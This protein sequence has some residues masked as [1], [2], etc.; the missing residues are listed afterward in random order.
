MPHSR[1]FLVCKLSQGTYCA[2][3]VCYVDGNKRPILPAFLEHNHSV[4]QGK[5][6]MV[7]SN[8]HILTGMVFGAALPHD[9]IAGD[10]FLTAENLNTESLAF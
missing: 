4:A 5:E 3:R 1:A 9:N 7:L 8:T 6:S 2:L 10:Y